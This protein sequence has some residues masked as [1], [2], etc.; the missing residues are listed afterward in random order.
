[1]P[2][3][4]PRTPSHPAAARRCSSSVAPAAEARAGGER[5]PRPR[6]DIGPWGFLC[7][8]LLGFVDRDAGWRELDEDGARCVVEE[9]RAAAQC[10]ILEP[11]GE[12]RRV[13]VEPERRLDASRQPAK[14]AR[15]TVDR[16]RAVVDA[17][18]RHVA[19]E[20]DWRADRAP[21]D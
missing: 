9:R 15:A 7:G 3:S 1:M 17:A 19:D 12:Q 4:R 14:G 10:T 11:S 5:R 21:S 16:V 18:W 13:P 8:L 2:P 20:Q 6:P